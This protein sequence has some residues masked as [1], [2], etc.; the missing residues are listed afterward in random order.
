MYPQPRHDAGACRVVDQ[1][2][3]MLLARTAVVTGPDLGPAEG[4]GTVAKTALAI[5]D[6]SKI[7]IHDPSKIDRPGDPPRVGWELPGR[8]SSASQRA[9]RLRDIGAISYLYP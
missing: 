1:A 8:W 9:G 6:P 3:G 5:H 2:G 7:D 4:V